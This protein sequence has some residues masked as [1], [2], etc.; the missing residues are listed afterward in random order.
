MERSTND[1]TGQRFGRLLVEGPAPNEYK[2]P[3]RR[4]W[5]C[6]CNCGT[7]CYHQTSDLTKTKDPVQSCGCLHSEI[8]AKRNKETAKWLGD[9]QKHE[10]LH[11]IWGAMKNRC[12]SVLNDNYYLYGGRGITIC[13]EWHDWFIFRDWALSHGYA[14][15]LTI[16]RIDTNGNYEPDNCRWVT[17]QVQANNTNRNKYLLYKGE[18]DTLANWCRRLNLDYFRT[19]ARLNTCGYS[20]EEAFELRRYE[21]RTT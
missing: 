15:N 18:T 14:D 20:V 13:E 1:L 4:M 2:K 10:R 3:G 7:I 17:Q 11:Q 8:L 5:Q 16:D 12:E 19:K 9:T 6:R 21:L